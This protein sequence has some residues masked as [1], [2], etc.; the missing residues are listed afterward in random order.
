[1]CKKIIEVNNLFKNYGDIQVLES[2]NMKIET[3]EVVAIIG[4]VD[5]TRPYIPYIY[6]YL[7]I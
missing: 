6:I 7:K 3:G 4:S 1:M 2:L 5:M